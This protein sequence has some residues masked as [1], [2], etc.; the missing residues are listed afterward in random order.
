MQS[1]PVSKSIQ[2]IS[3]CLGEY[4]TFQNA[5]KQRRLC[6]I[7]IDFPGLQGPRQVSPTGGG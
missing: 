7:L 2:N 5:Q 6:F 3:R 4:E 1:D